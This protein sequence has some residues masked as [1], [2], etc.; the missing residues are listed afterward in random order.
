[1]ENDFVLTKKDVDKAYM[2]K[3]ELE[4]CLGGPTKEISFLRQLYEKE[5]CELQSQILDMFILLYMNSSW[6]LDLDSIITG[7]KHQ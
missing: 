4:S 5:I 6:S 1:M 7:I 3:V 2:N